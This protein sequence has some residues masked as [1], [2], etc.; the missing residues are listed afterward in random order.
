MT[1]AQKFNFRMSS[2]WRKFRLK[3]KH[4]AN[5]FDFIT[6]KPLSKSWNLHH[7]DLR[8]CHYTDI[9]DADRFMALNKD[10]HDF[11]HWIYR[12]WNKDRGVLKRL[13]HTLERMQRCTTDN[14]QK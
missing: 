9:S 3:C 14:V 11:V 7:L 1:Q 5:C 12:L 8:D 13:E 10:T 4:R 6:K 2:A